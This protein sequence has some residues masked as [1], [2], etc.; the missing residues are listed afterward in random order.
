MVTIKDGQSFVNDTCR[1]GVIVI[2][3]H[4]IRGHR[5]RQLGHDG[6]EREVVNILIDLIVDINIIKNKTFFIFSHP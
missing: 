2:P 6:V 1:D 4:A 5:F 3:G